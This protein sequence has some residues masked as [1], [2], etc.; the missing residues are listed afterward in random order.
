[1]ASILDAFLV[2]VFVINI[3]LLGTS[4]INAVIRA[5][6]VQGLVLAVMP[7]LVLGRFDVHGVLI[8]VV[9]ALLKGVVIP[10]MVTRAVREVRIRREV[11]PFV[12]FG[13]SMLLGA[14]GAGAAL[15]FTR[16]L[17]LVPGEESRLIVPAA[18]ATV[19]TGFILLTTRLKA[20]NQVLGYLVLE[21]GIFIFGLLLLHAMP[22]VVEIGVLLDLVVAIFAMGILL[23]HIRREFSSLDTR[24]FSALKED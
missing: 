14:L 18:L 21:N 1:M 10:T 23:N 5:V 16:S 3:Y 15:A 19:L 13:A 6:A 2:I 22:L 24:N 11:E 20:V 9:A 12:S 7:T 8:G 4:R 17:P